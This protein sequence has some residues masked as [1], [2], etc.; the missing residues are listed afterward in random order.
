[1]L[2]VGLTGNVASGK[3]SVA[4]FW[5]EAGVPVLDADQ[6]AREAVAPGSPG[7]EEVVRAFG[8]EVLRADGSLDRDR[9]RDLVFR[10]PEAR[11]RLEAIVHPRVRARW[12]EWLA[13]QRRTGAPL[14]AAEVPLLFEAGLEGE[15]DVIVFVDA[16][17]PVRVARL[18]RARGL[19]REE[20]EHIL[21]A[22]MPAEEKRRRAHLVI[23]NSGTL[24]ALR[25]RALEALGALRGRAGAAAP[26][27]S[28]PEA[29]RPIRIDLHLHTSAS[30]DCLSEPQAVLARAEAAGLDR[31]AVTDHNELGAALELAARAPGRVIPGEEVRTVEGFDV[32][33]LYLSE[34]IPK[35]TPA[36]EVCERVHAQG[37]IVYLPHP[38]A[39]RKGGAGR[40]LEA[41]VGRVDV[42]EVLNA[43]LHRAELNRRAARWAERHGLPGGAGSD[44][45]TLGEIG[46]AYVEC[47]AH[48][49]EAQALLAALEAGRVG[50]RASPRSVHIASTWARLRKR[51]G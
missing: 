27:A 2:I 1:M 49:N 11:A 7:L 22:Q 16:P 47:P 33:G 5:R 21:A 3:S 50:G 48:P 29:G 20:A 8:P 46:A 34:P 51:L 43:R 15:F 25:A 40:H 31:I 13:R 14:V 32:I 41:L 17:E 37:G 4:A 36:A 9:M 44:A 42:V 28:A 10:D 35:G 45:H 18:V 23:D 39:A 26:G 12:D 24:D 38:F 19:S 30:H 6:A